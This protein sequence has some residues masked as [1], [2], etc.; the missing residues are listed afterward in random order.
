MDFKFFLAGI[1]LATI[2]CLASFLIIFYSFD[3]FEAGA[4]IIFLFFLSLFLSLVGF[5]GLLGVALRMV[6]G[7]ARDG[8][9]FSGSFLKTALRQGALLSFLLTG[10]LWLE[11]LEWLNWITGAILLM[12]VISFEAFSLKKGR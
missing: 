2:I 9:K 8:R 7:R 5:F 12:L 11:S 4:A 10:A 1:A 3:P 6:F